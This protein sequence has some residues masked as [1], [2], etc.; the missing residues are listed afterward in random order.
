LPLTDELTRFELSA[1]YIGTPVFVPLN[2]ATGAGDIRPLLRG[3]QFP[4]IPHSPH[5][6]SLQSQIVDV[7][8]PMEPGI[9]GPTTVTSSGHEVTADLGGMFEWEFSL[10]VQ[11]LPEGNSATDLLGPD[12]ALAP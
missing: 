6:L 4:D 5:E 11:T 2:Q 8:P 10:G 1:D 7:G 12:Y 9:V 3:F